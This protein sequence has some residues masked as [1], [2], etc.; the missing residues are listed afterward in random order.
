METFEVAAL[1]EEVAKRTPEG[2]PVPDGLA[3]DAGL[4]QAAVNAFRAMKVLPK[5][6]D[7]GQVADIMLTLATNG[8]P[9]V[10]SDV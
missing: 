4:I 7:V 2:K 5:G 9:V 3:Y 8:K 1:L 6:H 10:L